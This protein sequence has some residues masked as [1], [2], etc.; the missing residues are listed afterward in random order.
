MVMT[1]PESR[2]GTT[3]RRHRLEVAGGGAPPLRHDCFD[4]V[5]PS[6]RLVMGF[7]GFWVLGFQLIWA[8]L[9]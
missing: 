2:R 3:A 6:L 8:F 9:R 1:A 4:C 7:T 5:P